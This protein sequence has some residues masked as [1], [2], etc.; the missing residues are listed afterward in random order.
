MNIVSKVLGSSWADEQ[1]GLAGLVCQEEVKERG[2]G[3]YAGATVVKDH[4][5]HP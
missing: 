1:W 5:K 4:P 3:D 2:A